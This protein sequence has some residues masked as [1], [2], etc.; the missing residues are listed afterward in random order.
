MFYDIT[1][2][3][4]ATQYFVSAKLPKEWGYWAFEDLDADRGL[5]EVEAL[6]QYALQQYGADLSGFTLEEVGDE[7]FLEPFG[8][9]GELR[10]LVEFRF[11]D[12][13]DLPEHDGYVPDDEEAWDE[14]AFDDDAFDDVEDEE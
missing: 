4:S 5:P 1:I 9:E 12:F 10:E 13:R 2:N 7:V 6:H 14:D 11:V 8:P 3:Q